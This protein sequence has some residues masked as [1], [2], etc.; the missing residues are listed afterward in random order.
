MNVCY[1]NTFN[2]QSVIYKFFCLYSF[3]N[4]LHTIVYF[5]NNKC[6]NVII[7]LNLLYCII[8]KIY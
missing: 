7:V 5:I 6:G 4:C 3:N 1:R 8:L 2:M